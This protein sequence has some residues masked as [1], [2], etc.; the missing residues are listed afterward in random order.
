MLT[1]EE[2]A[3]L[4]KEHN[5]AGYIQFI[6]VEFLWRSMGAEVATY[7]LCHVLWERVVFELD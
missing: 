6:L 5:S 1:R 7:I 4:E 2:Y 3:R